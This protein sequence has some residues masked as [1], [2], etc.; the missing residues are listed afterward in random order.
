MRRYDA[1][2][3]RHEG[4]NLPVPFQ[5][6]IG[7]ADDKLERTLTCTAILRH[8]P[9][10][11]LVC[12]G[13][14]GDGT[15]VVAK[16]FLDPSGAERHYRRELLGIEAMRA[17]GI[18]TPDLLFQGRLADGQA[19]VLLLREM[20]GFD[21]LTERLEQCGADRR[22]DTLRPVVEAIAGLHAAGLRQRDIHPG[23]FLLSGE[24]VM[25]I[26][27]DDIEKPGP[28]PL[29]QKDSLANLTLFF[30]Q[31]HPAF[32]VMAPRLTAV[33]SACRRWPPQS[34]T[35]ESIKDA[36]QRWRMWRLKRFLPKTQRSCTAFIVQKKWHRFS[37]CD[38]EWYSPAC[39]A[40]LDDPD[41]F[42]KTG[43]I[44]KAG[45]TATV[46]RIAFDGQAIVVKRYNIKNMAHALNRSLRPSRAMVSW[47]NAHR[48]RF[49]GIATPRPLAVIEERWGFLRKRA[50][51]I[52]AHQP[53]T[54]ID[55]ALR[56]VL[57]DPQAVDHYLDQLGELLKQLA[58]ARIS[59][60]DCK[61]TNFLV[62]AEG[63]Y[64]VDL[65][66]MRAHRSKAAYRQSFRRDMRRLLRNWQDLPQVHRGL[67]ARIAKAF[68]AAG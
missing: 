1:Q 59:H 35:V 53:G 11:R 52:M 60:G 40:L 13:T 41:A 36:I 22:F 48:L 10:K 66:G 7:M 12:S 64:L 67:T 42:I 46:A 43:T 45:N 51:F 32:D 8:L 44:L 38:R 27:G 18:P 21:N 62:S 3:L 31:F 4:R 5:L 9:G 20:R 2:A 6:S 55:Q 47:R 56:G 54:S 26:D 65:D 33:Y 24:R 14:R 57:D 25:I 68:Q 28:A 34:V 15:P 29:S 39:Q 19:P 50:F 16:I 61:A 37:A 63:L 30:A 49:L 58:A 23:N 17:G